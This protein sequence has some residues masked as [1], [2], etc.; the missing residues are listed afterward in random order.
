MA[1][2]FVSGAAVLAWEVHPEWASAAAVKKYLIAHSRPAADL[3]PLCVSGAIL[4]LASLSADQPIDLPPPPP[5][6]AKKVEE[7]LNLPPRASG[8]NSPA[9]PAQFRAPLLA[10]NA[11]SRRTD[12]PIDPDPARNR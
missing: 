7:E 12:A 4:N 2:A 3:K 6:D 8:A 1:T 11:Q 10:G 5:P 9:D